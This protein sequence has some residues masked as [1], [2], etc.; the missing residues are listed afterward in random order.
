MS[1][2]FFAFLMDCVIGD[3]RSSWHPVVLIGKWIACLE[4]QLNRTA[5][6]AGKQIVK[7]GI[8]VVL[9]LAA[10]WG[11]SAGLLWLAFFLNFYLGTILEALLLSFMISP[12]SLAE[13]GME[14]R[15]YLLADNLKQARFKVGWIV[16]RDTDQLTSG[17]VTRATVETVAENLVDG[18]IAPLFFFW[19]GGAPLAVLYRAVNTM[20][21]MLGYKNERYLYFG[22]AAAR[23]DDVLN[24]I[25][26]RITGVLVILSAFI[27]RLDFRNALHIMQR[28]A[29]KHPSPNGGYPEASVAG[30]LHIQ[31]GGVNYYF[32]QKHFRAYMGDAEQPLRPQH[33]TDTI[34]IMYTVT[35]L[36]LCLFSIGT[37]WGG[38]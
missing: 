4:K 22:R 24:W 5:D 34:R 9:V 38:K 28:D 18:V 8:V 23:L 2:S 26:A 17:E 33:I 15:N 19:L 27:L 11:I 12:R 16:G 32:G 36:F 10:A 25:P 14:I 37:L 29:S 31:L 21:S 20:D 30:A 3:P 6:S 7:G 1:I 13:A 35:V